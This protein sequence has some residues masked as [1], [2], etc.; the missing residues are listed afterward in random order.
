MKTTRLL[1]TLVVTLAGTAVMLTGCG[2]G[3][4]DR[5]TPPVGKTSLERALSTEPESLDPQKGR[6]VE[7][8]DVLRDIG[9]GLV[10]FNAAGELVPGTA[11]SWEIAADGLTYTFRIRPEA[12]WSNGD[13]VTAADFVFGLRRL[14]DPATAA[15]YAAELSNVVN[16]TAVITGEMAPTELGVSAPDERTFVMSLVRPTPYLLSLLTHPSTFP[17][18]RASVEQHREA[19][20]RA[21]NLLSNG[22]YVLVGREPGAILELHRN[23]HYWNDAETSIDV[24][25]HHVVTQELSQFHR[26]RAGELQLTSTVP[27]ENFEQI[28]AEYGD[29]LRIAPTLGVYY[30]GFNLTKPPFAGN[31]ELRQALS[32]A[33]DR[34]V[35]VEAITGRGEAP[36]Y[37]W[38]PPGV[39][40]YEPVQLP[41]AGL[42]QQERA[43]IA[44]SLYRKA[45]YSK[46][47]PLRFELR[48]N[49]SDTH[50]KIALAIQAMW[51]KV[52]GAEATIVNVE[53]QVLLDQMR[54]REITEAFRASWFGDYNDANSFLA[55]M[56]SDSAA[57][58]PGYSNPEFDALMQSAGEQLDFDRRRLYLEEAER[59]LL[60]DH[61][62]I[63][64]Y[65]YVSKHLV[66]PAVRG[67]R[68][69]ILNYH[70]SQHLSLD[71][72]E[73]DA[74][75]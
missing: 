33:I 25:R 40:N 22:A 29:E 57:N 5:A 34:E 4:S 28:R 31:P 67:W 1:S 27:P 59:V 48:Y 58:I 10:T 21:G 55:I 41:Y 68:D 53:F 44:Q 61:A 20:A 19:F 71:G 36:A 43:A 74:R 7:A 14:V 63:P 12:R 69:N 56:Q 2:K 35:L 39:H 49:T 3:G 32:M 50:Q 52:L 9:E 26:Y 15:F 47:N 62:V 38:V 23:T 30:Y 75:P 6:S 70:Y 60:T 73:Q 45:G 24:V 72:A 18:H 13:P 65:F 42:S 16:A 8:A 17:V 64:L 37:S 46:D 51:R 11:E 66:K 54:E